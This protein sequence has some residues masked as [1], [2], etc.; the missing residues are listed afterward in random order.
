MVSLS[1]TVAIVSALALAGCDLIDD[2]NHSPH[3][4]F[5]CA[6]SAGCGHSDE[7]TI[8]GNGDVFGTVYMDRKFEI[9]YGTVDASAWNE[10]MEIDEYSID[11]ADDVEVIAGSPYRL[12]SYQPFRAS[13]AGLSVI[14]AVNDSDEVIDYMYIDARPGPATTNPDTSDT[15]ASDTETDEDGGMDGGT[16]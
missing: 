15:D 10:D 6:D 11:A 3:F 13:E 7:D 2:D 4:I 8:Y 12:G 9:Y 16:K 1:R 5:R 14:I